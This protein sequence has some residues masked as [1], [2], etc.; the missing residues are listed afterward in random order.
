M[1]VSRKR[2][3]LASSL[4]P[5]FI[6]SPSAI[7]EGHWIKYLGVHISSDLS[8]SAHIDTVMSKARTTRCF[9]YRKFYRNVNTF[10]LTKLYT[11]LVH[12][13]LEYSDAV[14]DLIFKRTS[15]NWSQCKE[16]PARSVPRIGQLLI[17]I[18]CVL[19]TIL[20]NVHS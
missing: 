16:E 18:T 10:V 14:W 5:L 13:L 9:I 4:H 17:V 8:W 15:I 19:L 11:T 12:P 1:L 20:N 7:M 6:G 3:S 2:S